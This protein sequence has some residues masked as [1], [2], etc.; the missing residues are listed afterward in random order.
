[1]AGRGGFQEVAYRIAAGADDVQLPL[2]RHGLLVEDPQHHQ[3]FWAQD[4]SVAEVDDDVRCPSELL[5]NQ[6]D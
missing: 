1:V 6:L 5:A 2:T 3:S 4:T